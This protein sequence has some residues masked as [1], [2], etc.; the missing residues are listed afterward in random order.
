VTADSTDSESSSKNNSN[1]SPD[2]LGPAANMASQFDQASQ[3]QPQLKV[4]TSTRFCDINGRILLFLDA[5]V[6][7]LGCVIC[8]RT[9]LFW[10]SLP[11][12]C[13]VYVVPYPGAMSLASPQCHATTSKMLM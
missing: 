4:Y 5:L 6:V 3:Q 8:F 11:W 1:H 9:D 10:A 2:Q 12:K 7:L 13:I